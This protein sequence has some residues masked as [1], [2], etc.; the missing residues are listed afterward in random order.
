MPL[1]S[2]AWTQENDDKREINRKKI[3]GWHALFYGIVIGLLFGGMALATVL[4]IWLR[5]TQTT[6]SSSSIITL[7]TTTT[8]LITTPTESTTSTTDDGSVN[9]RCTPHSNAKD[10][11]GDSNS[12]S[13][14]SN[15]TLSQ[16]VFLLNGIQGYTA[17]QLDSGNM[18]LL[19]LV[20]MN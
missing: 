8:S 2:N 13:G 1:N 5:S 4:I 15:N 16:S 3:R 20:I 10:F 9:S 6:I 7:L 11:Y 17:A 12:S 18:A 14:V 19:I